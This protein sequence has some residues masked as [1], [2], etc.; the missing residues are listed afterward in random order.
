MKI[1]EWGAYQS[2][3]ESEGRI[4]KEIVRITKPRLLFE[5]G[6]GVGYAT[7]WMVQGMKEA[8]LKGQSVI[9]SYDTRAVRNSD[10]IELGIAELFFHLIPSTKFLKRTSLVFDFAFL[11]GDHSAKVVYKEL[12]HLWSSGCRVF[13]LHDVRLD[14]T[15]PSKALK[16]FGYKFGELGS[17]YR[18]PNSLA[19][20][21]PVD[22]LGQIREPI[23]A[24]CFIV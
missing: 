5:S 11:D 14:D 22:L 16:K 7:G 10:N 1:R 6:T 18:L 3:L 15:G 8:G 2:I 12:L 19:T 21:I 17:W 24:K 4:L 9:H 20:N 23:E 13:V